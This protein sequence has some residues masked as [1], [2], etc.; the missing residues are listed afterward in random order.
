M[1]RGDRM[2]RVKV[3]CRDEG[4]FWARLADHVAKNGIRVPTGSP[5]PVGARVRVGL[6]FKDGRTLSGDGVV[7][8]HVDL[9]AGRGMCV[10][11]VKLD[12]AGEAAA[13]Q[14]ASEAAPP[15]AGG[16]RAPRVPPPVPRVAPLEEELFED[17]APPAP[18][19][20]AAALDVSGEVVAEM[21][22]R[23]ARLRRAAA[24]IAAAAV[25]V[26]VLGTVV[27]R[28]GAPGADAVVA[29]HVS[30]ADRLLAEGRLVGEDGAL[31]RL[32]AAQR[33]RPG[34][35]ATA[36]RLARAADL[37]EGLG[38]SAL[39]RRDLAVAAI[40]LA[41]ARLAAPERASIRAKLAAVERARTGGATAGRRR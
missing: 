36:D 9:A 27:S 14:A 29:A 30:A 21:A 10:R 15:V 13:P 32:L 23:G 8:S 25:A 26:A 12:R 34:D 1:E 38:E 24:G 6:E 35:P 7:A 2:L 33:V 37:L 19:S 20:G 39:A 22:R 11:F 18:A 5:R 4:E 31:A 16:A 40:H 17:A 28:I 3:P 41:N